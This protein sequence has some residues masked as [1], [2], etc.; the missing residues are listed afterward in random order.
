MNMRPLDSPV[1]FAV[2]VLGQ[3]VHEGQE[4]FLVD[5]HPVRILIGG[6][7]S[8]KSFACAVLAAWMAVVAAMRGKPLRILLT[9]PTIDQARVLLG[10]VLKLLRSSPLLRPLITREVESPFPQVEL[11]ETVVV[12]VRSTSEKGRHLRGHG[13]D[14]GLVIL[15]EAFLIDEPT[16]TTVIAPLLADTGGPLVLSSTATA[17]VGSYLHRL[18]ERGQAGD[19]RVKSFRF[20]S[21]DNVFLDRSYVLAQKD[22]ISEQ[23]WLVEW[24]GEFAAAVDSVFAWDKVVACSEGDAGVDA[25]G[26]KRFVVGFDPAKLRDRSAVITLDVSAIPRRV[27]A[28]E[29]LHGR[30]YVVQAARVAELSK[31][32]GSAKVVVDVTNGEA[33]ADLLRASGVHTVE[34]V[35]FSGG[36]KTE[37]ITGLIVAIE[38]GDVRFPPDRRLLDELRFFHAKRMPTGAV[39]Y[40][41]SHQAH[42]DFICALALAVHGAGVSR[43]R[44]PAFD[45]LPPFIGGGFTPPIGTLVSTPGGLDDRSWSD[46]PPR[47]RW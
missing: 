28:L 4:R 19:A 34:G 15:D 46:W 21:L 27:V 47:V 13:R 6:R 33:L 2:G 43:S 11:A 10:Y 24:E 40:E 30:N 14:L 7:R 37:L 36:R 5:D 9:A 1:A 17:P 38:R 18:F 39:R 26:G 35:N 22:E 32:H 44:P 3:Q 20:R 45:V 42:D 23:E 12:M 25:D 16:V 8:G 31:Q 41:A 29:D